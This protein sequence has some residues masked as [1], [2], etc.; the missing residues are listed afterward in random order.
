METKVKEGDI[1]IGKVMPKGETEPTPE[2]KLLKAIFGNKVGDVKDVSLRA[3]PSSRGVV[4]DSRLFAR[5]KKNKE[6]Q[7]R[8]TK[9]F[10]ERYQK[11]IIKP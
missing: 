3:S 5:G 4:I 9:D 11:I 8:K 1:I 2:E 6:L 7:E 10:E